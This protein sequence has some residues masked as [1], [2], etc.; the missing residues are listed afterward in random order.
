VLIDM[1]NGAPAWDYSIAGQ[2]LVG[3]DGKYWFCSTERGVAMLVPSEVPS[4]DVR[5]SISKLRPKPI[6]PVIGPGSRVSVQVGSLAGGLNPAEAQKMLEEQVRLRGWKI[7][8]NAPFRL[9]ASSQESSE[10]VTY[11]GSGGQQTVSVRKV[12]TTCRIADT[13]GKDVWK[14]EFQSSAGAPFFVMLQQGQSLQSEINKGFDNTIRNSLNGI[15]IPLVIFPPD[16]YAKL[17][18]STLTHKG[19]TLR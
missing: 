18:R 19:E 3:P 14:V 17:N 10:S 5:K 12:M 1:E 15:A 13:A 4:D 9:F 8:P 2:P 6:A 16:A 11:T 7:D